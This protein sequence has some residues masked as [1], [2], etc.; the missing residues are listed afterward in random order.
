[1][2]GSVWGVCEKC[3]CAHERARV[4]EVEGERGADF[5]VMR[6]KARLDPALLLL[7]P[8]THHHS[9]PPRK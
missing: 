1:M 8:L 2:R 7:L 4:G 5:L 3:V 6:P 9:T